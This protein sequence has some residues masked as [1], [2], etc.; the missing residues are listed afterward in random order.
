[1]R[2]FAVVA[3]VLLLCCACAA[4]RGRHNSG[5]GVTVARVPDKVFREYLLEQGYAVP[6]KGSMRR[7]GVFTPREELLES[8]PMGRAVQLLNVYRMG[9]GSLEGVELL[10]N[11]VILICSENPLQEVDLSH[12]PRLKQFVANEVPL[13]HVDLS[14]NAELKLVE[15]SFSQLEALDVSRNARLEEIYCIFSPGIEM[16]DLSGTPQLQRLYIRE[17][18]IREVDITPCPHFRELH[19]LD[20]PL[21]I[22]YATESQA[23][24]VQAWVE[25]SVRMELRENG[26]AE[27]YN[28]SSS[29]HMRVLLEPFRRMVRRVRGWTRR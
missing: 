3:A 22:I 9:I 18:S 4:T 2:R 7:W 14:H 5:Y 1:M 20:T 10:G 23:D 25:D 11:L 21:G 28:T 15:V 17:T 16:L 6:Y 29:S 8:T 24:V 12:F 27:T 19:A 13:R 26:S